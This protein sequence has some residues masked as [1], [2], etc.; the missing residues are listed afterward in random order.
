[1]SESISQLEADLSALNSAIRSGLLMVQVGGQLTQY[2]SLKQMRSVAS[3]LE[4]QIADCKGI[5]SQK[6]RV[7]SINTS[8]GV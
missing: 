7:S 5:A 1:M 6:P 4:R 8:R 3:D 2:Q